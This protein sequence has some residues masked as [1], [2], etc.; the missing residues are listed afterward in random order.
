M[1][2][3]CEWM[4]NGKMWII[5]IIFHRR[6]HLAAFPR[7]ESLANCHLYR[8]NVDELLLLLDVLDNRLSSDCNRFSSWAVEQQSHKSCCCQQ[9]IA[10]DLHVVRVSSNTLAINLLKQA[11]Q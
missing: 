2:H 7:S 11:D 4:W 10:H 1:D 8:T 3:E 9:F 5:T 6:L